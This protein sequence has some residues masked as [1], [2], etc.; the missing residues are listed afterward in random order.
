MWLGEMCQNIAMQ[1]WHLDG[2][3]SPR[4][5]WA[6]TFRRAMRKLLD[7]QGDPEAA[8]PLAPFKRLPDFIYKW[9][10]FLPLKRR[11]R[12]ALK[13]VLKSR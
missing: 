9:N 5:T 4:G 6:Q 1:N 3:L 2:L 8:K 10:G 7:I 13:F 11:R 12:L